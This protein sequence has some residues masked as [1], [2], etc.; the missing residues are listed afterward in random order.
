MRCTEILEPPRNLILT[1]KHFRY[2]TRHHIR[3][4]LLY[5]VFHDEIISVNV[6]GSFKTNSTR[7]VD[8]KLYA[9]I[10][11]SG[12]SLDSGHY[13]TIARESDNKWFKFNDSYVTDTS[14]SELR[15]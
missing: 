6:K 2:D 12:T 8:Y 3:S 13:Y 11:H 7:N 5:K 10:I 4:K 15:R 9:A 14:L 1:L